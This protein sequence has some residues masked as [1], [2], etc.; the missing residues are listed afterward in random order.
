MMYACNKQIQLSF[1]QLNRLYWYIW[2]NIP[3]F[4]IYIVRYWKPASIIIIIIIMWKLQDLSTNI[5]THEDK[6]KPGS[7]HSTQ[8]CQETKT[9]ITLL[10]CPSVKIS[11]DIILTCLLH[12]L[13]EAQAYE[14][15]QKYNFCT[16]TKKKKN[17]LIVKYLKSFENLFSSNKHYT[18]KLFSATQYSGSK[19]LELSHGWHKRYITKEISNTQHCF[20][21]KPKASTEHL[22]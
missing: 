5:M 20:F 10:T 8:R 18:T 17:S 11:C 3:H 9:L 19:G 2:I 22:K 15:P 13:T 16:Q 4:V 6:W 1:T 14:Q 7:D 21:A 12:V